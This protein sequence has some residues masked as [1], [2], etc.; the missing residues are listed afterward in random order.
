MKTKHWLCI[1]LQI[2]FVLFIFPDIA[3]C[4][5][6]GLP[7]DS[8]FTKIEAFLLGPFLR[9]AAVCAIVLAGLTLAIDI[10]SG[11]MRQLA[12][13]CLGIGLAAGGTSIIS[14]IFNISSG[15]GF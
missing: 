15:L 10:H 13:V 14:N 4:S 9:F 12:Q 6:S 5:S 3:Q 7:F 11:I 1:I 8:I 2:T